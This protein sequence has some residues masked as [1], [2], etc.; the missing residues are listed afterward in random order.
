VERKKP[1]PEPETEIR[2]R[3]AR[4]VEVLRECLD[5]LQRLERGESVVV[6]LRPDA[7]VETEFVGFDGRGW[8]AC[9]N[10]LQPTWI[11]SAWYRMTRMRT[12]SQTTMILKHVIAIN[13]PSRHQ[14]RRN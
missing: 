3:L 5:W 14:S 4:E 6:N 7:D 8:S 9:W 13:W 1:R 12:R 2:S 11:T 10:E